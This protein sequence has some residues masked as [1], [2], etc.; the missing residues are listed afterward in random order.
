MFFEIYIQMPKK[1]SIY[2]ANAIAKINGGYCLSN[3]Y[4]NNSIDLEWKCAKGHIFKKPLKRV[5]RSEWCPYCS[6]K[7][8]LLSIKELNRVAESRGGKYLGD[9]DLIISNVAD[10]IC[11]DGHRWRSIVNNVVN[12]GSWCK[13][14][15]NNNG[16][17]ISRYIFENFTGKFFPTKR[18][19]W[20]RFKGDK[21]SLE[22]DGFNE[23]FSI[24]F[25]HQG[26]Q[27]YTDRQSVSMFASESIARND[28]NKIEIC[29]SYGVSILLIPQVGEMTSLSELI[30]LIKSFLI[31]HNVPIIKNVS[32]SEVEKNFDIVKKSR[33]SDLKNI[34][35][36]KGGDCLSSVYLGHVSPLKFVCSSGHIWE[37]RPNDIKR[38]SWCSVCS[39]AGGKKKKIEDLKVMFS[40]FGVEC[41]SSVYSTSREKYLWRCAKGHEFYLR[42]DYL[43][44]LKCCPFCKMGEN[45]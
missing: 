32:I 17:Q 5:K 12:L 16:E 14:C 42:Y 10:W 39:R 43:K 7:Y 44:N 2:D 31:K 30:T 21:R 23:E 20:L 15:R 36:S 22:L 24:A 33:I 18:P 34:A 3:N 11:G 26:K 38:G 1:L 6:G 4:V 27:H 9:R 13:V 19:K 35:K 45:K 37:A 41:I 40:D 8:V 29:K 25:E 28:I